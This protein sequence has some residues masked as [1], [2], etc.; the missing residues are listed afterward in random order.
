MP[1]DE[2]LVSTVDSRPVNILG[3]PTIHAPVAG[4]AEENQPLQTMES[5]T[6]KPGLFPAEPPFVAIVDDENS[7]VGDKESES[8]PKSPRVAHEEEKLV[9][10]SMIELDRDVDEKKVGLVPPPRNESRAG[11]AE[12]AERATTSSRKPLP[13]WSVAEVANW[14]YN[15]VGVRP[16]VVDVLK[17]SGLDGSK[18][19]T[20]NDALLKDIGVPQQL[21]RES[22]LDAIV[23]LSAESGSTVE[24]PPAYIIPNP[25]TR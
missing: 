15:V 21:V 10:S 6:N 22:I 19:L 12:R 17:A 24:M 8:G 2:F 3:I 9:S 11:S 18:L 25:V 14:L 20:L 1:Q 13:T 23:Q 5:A 4:A 16:D 7:S